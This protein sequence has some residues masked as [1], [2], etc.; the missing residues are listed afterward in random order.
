MRF[1]VL[2]NTGHTALAYE[3]TE[4]DMARAE[5]DFQRLT[6]KEKRAA[7]ALVPGG[8][9]AVPEHVTAL[10]KDAEEVTFILPLQ[11]G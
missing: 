9:P 1:L 10:P 6:A 7:F 2:D 8:D 4:A 5:A 3:P 11:G